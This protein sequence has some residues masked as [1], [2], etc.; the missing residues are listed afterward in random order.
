ARAAAVDVR[1]AG[2]LRAARLAAAAHDR[3]ALPDL[4][5]LQGA[6]PRLPAG[7]AL[8]ALRSRDVGGA[9]VNTR[10]GSPEPLGARFDGRGTNF[11]VLAAPARSVTVCLFEDAPGGGFR[12][13]A[14]VPLPA[15]TGD[16][17]HGWLPVGPGTLYGLRVDG[18][19][20]PARGLRCNAAK[21]LLDPWA[22]AV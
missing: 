5:P 7:R 19:W 9:H 16:R 18:P 12:E 22:L 10:A 17:F 14:R 2:A 21:L 15:R 3:Q 11:A 13:T 1:G 8:P 6:V 20:D 4:L